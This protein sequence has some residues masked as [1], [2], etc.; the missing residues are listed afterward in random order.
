MGCG[1]C[2]PDK[3][4]DKDWGIEPFLNNIKMLLHRLNMI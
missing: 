3:D 2:G 1:E 4:G